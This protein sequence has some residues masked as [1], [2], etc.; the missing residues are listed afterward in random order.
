MGVFDDFDEINSSP[1][2]SPS[3]SSSSPSPSPSLSP[4]PSPF[5]SLSPSPSPS[6]CPSSSSI[7]PYS[8]HFT[9]P[10]TFEVILTPI[11]TTSTDV[12]II[13]KKLPAEA[14]QSPGEI[15]CPQ[16]FQTPPGKEDILGSRKAE[17]LHS[18]FYFN[19]YHEEEKSK[20]DSMW[21]HPIIQIGEIV[22]GD[23]KL[24][25]FTAHHMNTKAVPQKKEVRFHA[26][27]LYILIFELMF[28]FVTPLGWPLD[29]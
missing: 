1:S 23:E 18:H 14:S 24:F 26:S 6:F 29:L 8:F 12:M 22:S 27:F 16:Y 5:P 25:H 19:I 20:L 17:F 10:N 7:S 11:S 15:L 3:S 4:S 2:P 13:Q 9:L 21:M 28:L